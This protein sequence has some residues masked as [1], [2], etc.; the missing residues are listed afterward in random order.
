MTPP[1]VDQGGE[2]IQSG[3]VFTVTHP[4][5][6]EEVS[7]P[8]ADPEATGLNLVMSWRPGIRDEL[9]DQWGSSDKFADGVGAQILTVVSVH[10]PGR[11]PRRVFYTRQWRSPDGKVFGKP[12]LRIKAINAFKT[13]VKGYRHG[14]TVKCSDAATPTLD[15]DERRKR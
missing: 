13:L 3:Q 7:L 11:Y 5:I 15:A 14:F 10:K 2:A 6:R 8:P 9:I 1:G 4:F 12:N